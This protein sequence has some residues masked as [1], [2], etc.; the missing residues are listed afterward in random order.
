VAIHT[1]TI[2]LQPE[3]DYVCHLPGCALPLS[4]T[5]LLV[6]NVFGSKTLTYDPVSLQYLSPMETVSVPGWTHDETPGDAWCTV[7]AT[8]TAE[9]RWVGQAIDALGVDVFGAS[10]IHTACYE[11]GIGGMAGPVHW[12]QAAATSDFGDPPYEPG[13][14]GDYN[15]PPDF[16]VEISVDLSSQPDDVYGSLIE[17]VVTEIL[18]P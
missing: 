14:A 18:P 12:T 5:L 2:N 10:P 13:L 7:P 8:V 1:G 11:E 6:D 9:V 17:Q 4:R 16:L 3:A 15:C